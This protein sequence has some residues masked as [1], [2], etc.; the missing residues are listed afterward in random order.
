M[1]RTRYFPQAGGIITRAL[2]IWIRAVWDLIGSVSEVLDPPTRV[3]YLRTL[4]MLGIDL[5]S[6]LN[7]KK[8]CGND[9]L[10]GVHSGILAPFTKSQTVKANSEIITGNIITAAIDS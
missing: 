1:A 8:K 6:F 9:S 3:A 5:G 10:S 4:Q 7:K 2:R